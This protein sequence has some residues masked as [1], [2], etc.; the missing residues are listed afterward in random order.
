MLQ[1]ISDPVVSIPMPVNCISHVNRPNLAGTRLEGCT[2]AIAY[3]DGTTRTVQNTITVFS[4]HVETKAIAYQETLGR[5]RALAFK[6]FLENF[7]NLL[8]PASRRHV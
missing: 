2:H 4:L 1:D 8:I 3:Q 6:D 7:A 5:F